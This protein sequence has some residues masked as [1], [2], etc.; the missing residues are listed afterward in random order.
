MPN[1]KLEDI[2]LLYAL[3]EEISILTYIQDILNFDIDYGNFHAKELHNAHTYAPSFVLSRQIETVSR[4]WELL[5]KSDFG[6]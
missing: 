2:D 6:V 3:I 5:T 1:I 4:I